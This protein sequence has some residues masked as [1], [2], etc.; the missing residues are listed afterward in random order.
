MCIAVAELDRQW[1]AVHA[2]TVGMSCADE[3]AY[4][5]RLDPVI[6]GL[7][8]KQSCLLDAL[9]AHPINAKPHAVVV[10][11]VASSGGY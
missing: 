9:A 11:R 7:L 4:L 3:T 5:E 1:D 6:S 10:A 2:K 8:G